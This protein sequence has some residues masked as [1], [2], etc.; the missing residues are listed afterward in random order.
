MALLPVF[1][2]GGLS[3]AFFQPLAISYALAVLASMLVALTVTPALAWILL[4]DAPVD[5][6]ES[7]IV[8]LAPG[9]AT[10]SCPAS[11]APTR[12]AFA[13]VGA[14]ALAGILVIPQLGPVLLPRSRN[15]TS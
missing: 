2:I 9:A 1:M 8:R 12:P 15:G 5:R 7:H 10:A 13:A 14:I 4:R 3:G 6:R 11:I